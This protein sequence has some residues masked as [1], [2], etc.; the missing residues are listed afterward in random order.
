MVWQQLTGRSIE[1][2]VGDVTDYEFL[3]SMITSFKPEVIVHFAEQRSAPYSM[4]DR[5]TPYSRK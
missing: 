3:A 1:T 5:S 2:F 4:I